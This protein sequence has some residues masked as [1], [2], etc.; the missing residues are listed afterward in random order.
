MRR[1]LRL[2]AVVDELLTHF[3]RILTARPLTVG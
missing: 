2:L 3:L 1:T